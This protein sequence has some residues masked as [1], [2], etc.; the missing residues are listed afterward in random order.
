M[1]TH[2]IKIQNPIT[3]GPFKKKTAFI[4]LYK[5]FQYQEKILNVIIS[6]LTIR[7]LLCDI[8]VIGRSDNGFRIGRKACLAHS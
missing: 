2:D 8:V 7:I 1:L 5:P 3:S 4:P 6:M